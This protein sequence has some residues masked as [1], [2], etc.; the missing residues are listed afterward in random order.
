MLAGLSRSASGWEV[1]RLVPIALEE[2]GAP[3]LNAEAAD[4]LA[5]MPVRVLDH[6]GDHPRLRSLADLA[7]GLDYP[8]GRIG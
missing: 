7:P 2:T 8:G 5:R 6:A 3:A 4:V 1:D